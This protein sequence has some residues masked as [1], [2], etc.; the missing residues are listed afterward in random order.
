MGYGGGSQAE[1]QDFR[2]SGVASGGYQPVQV[3][4][5]ECRL[6]A[7]G[8]DSRLNA[9]HLGE[10]H[11]VLEAVGERCGESECLVEL[12]CIK[13]RAER[14]HGRPAGRL[15]HSAGVRIC[16]A[17]I[18][19][20]DGCLGALK[21][22]LCKTEVVVQK[23]DFA[24]LSGVGG[25]SDRLA[26]VLDSCRVSDVRARRAA[27]AERP[28][29]GGSKVSSS[30]SVS[31]RSADADGG[32]RAALERLCACD[33]AERF[34]QRGAGRERVEQRE[35]LW[36]SSAQRGSPRENSTTLSEFNAW[37]WAGRSPRA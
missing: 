8:M 7:E 2:S 4:G 9:A 30:A 21:G 17:G 34:D 14:A 36:G 37:A 24:S 28:R 10:G 23:G 19:L 18:D 12:A 11:V 31:A 33:L 35:R 16:D 1:D 32:V 25:E 27:I 6:A 15:S 20:G 13:Q 22:P 29:A 26:H 5:G 3:V